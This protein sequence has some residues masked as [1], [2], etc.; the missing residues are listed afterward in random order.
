MFLKLHNYIYIFDNNSDAEKYHT[1][2]NI[3]N[4]SYQVSNDDFKFFLEYSMIQDV[5][6]IKNLSYNELVDLINNY[7][8]II[9]CNN[10]STYYAKIIKLLVETYLDNVSKFY[11]LRNIIKINLNK[12][13]LKGDKYLFLYC[14]INKFKIVIKKIS[15]P[16]EAEYY[17]LKDL[18]FDFYS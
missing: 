18:I 9:N 10:D 11:K 17:E 7:I 1:R 16:I 2:I 3:Q 8:S 12:I 6:D 15:L 14:F 4:N 5:I 13:K